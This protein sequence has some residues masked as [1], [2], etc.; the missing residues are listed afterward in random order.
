M[1]QNMIEDVNTRENK[2]K[3]QPLNLRNFHLHQH[4]KKFLTT[5]LHLYNS[6]YS[7][8]IKPKWIFITWN[9]VHILKLVVEDYVQSL[10]MILETTMSKF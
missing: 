3:S 9:K 1:R 5:L 10:Q 7:I 6:I 8:N 2:K 4:G